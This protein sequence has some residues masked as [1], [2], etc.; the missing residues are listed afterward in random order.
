MQSDPSL[1]QP[2][3]LFPNHATK[4][5]HSLQEKSPNRWNIATRPIRNINNTSETV[6]NNKD[7]VEERKKKKG[8][9]N[10]WMGDGE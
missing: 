3:A 10:R 2:V 4:W 9:A 5:K 6:Q 1:L 8:K 7:E